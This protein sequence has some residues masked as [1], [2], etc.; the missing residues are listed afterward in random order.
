MRVVALIVGLLAIHTRAEHPTSDDVDHLRSSEG[1][2]GAAINRDDHG[3][4]SYRMSDTR[5]QDTRTPD[6]VPETPPDRTNPRVAELS[7]ANA[8]FSF[9]LYRSLVSHRGPE[10]NVFLSPLSISTSFAMTKLGACGD[11]LRQIMQVFEFESIKEKTSSQIHMFFSKLNDRLYRKANKSAQLVAANRLFGDKSVAFNPSYQE[12]SERYY[13]A[14]LLPLN[15]ADKTNESLF[16]INNWV[17]EKTEGKVKNV[18]PPDGITPET[19][20]VIVNAIFFKGLWKQKFDE[21]YTYLTDFHPALGRSCNVSMM[22]KKGRFRHARLESEGLQILELPYHGD[23]FSI[24]LL[25]PT[26][27]YQLAE[28]EA[29]MSP[30]SMNRW[31]KAMREQQVFV[32]LP[33]F[34]LED[35]FSLKEHLHDLGLIDIFSAQHADLSGMIVPDSNHRG[36]YASDAYHKAF[37]EVNEAGSEAGAAS[38]IVFLARSS[39]PNME[40]FHADQPFVMLIREVALNSVLFLGR[41]TQPCN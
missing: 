14:K 24:I 11:T 18:I 35:S 23:A 7:R 29:R 41:V 37:I 9:K 12:F 33:R 5:K 19:Q 28:I 20:L 16:T 32:S 21:Y 40:E 1:S 17:A 13:G 38:A 27:R 25:L 31:L 2:S 22:E 36:L 4:C 6:D 8:A 10:A 3:F 26:R 39:Q 34:K 15:F 30:D